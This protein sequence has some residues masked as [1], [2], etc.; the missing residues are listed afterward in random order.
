MKQNEN[1]QNHKEESTPVVDNKPNGKSQIKPTNLQIFSSCLIICIAISSMIDARGQQRIIPPGA[2]PV[3]TNGGWTLITN[4]AD[5][6]PGIWKDSTN[7]LRIEIILVDTNTLLASACVYVG[8]LTTNSSAGYFAPEKGPFTKCEL[9][10]SNGTI[11]VPK[12]GKT[13]EAALAPEIKVTSLQKDSKGRLKG[14]II[15]DPR[16]PGLIK[17]FRFK[18]VYN[19]EKEG[20][21][22]FTIYPVIYQGSPLGAALKRVDLPRLSAKVHLLPEAKEE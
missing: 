6:W 4:K 17:E 12:K 13:L 5:I 15:F 7:G 3:E 10:D 11:I 21:Y 19:I 2:I 20:D 14:H 16:G 9:L 8:S 18:D 1:D 22:V